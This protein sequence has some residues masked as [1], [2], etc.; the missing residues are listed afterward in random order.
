MQDE[1]EE[2]DDEEVMRAEKDLEVRFL[3]A[4]WDGRVDEEH[5]E[6]D[7]KACQIREAA[8]KRQKETE[9]KW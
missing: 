9:Q 8:W 5:T 4:L 3:H 6:G 1:K 2:E 7:P